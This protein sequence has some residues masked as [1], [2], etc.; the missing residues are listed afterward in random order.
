MV[1]HRSIGANGTYAGMTKFGHMIRTMSS[2]RLL[3]LGLVRHRQPV[4]GYELHRELS[5]WNVDAWSEL[6]SGSIYHALS[7]M[8]LEGLL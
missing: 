6:K 3:V 8:A 5:A 2:T 7:R 4:H 1:Q